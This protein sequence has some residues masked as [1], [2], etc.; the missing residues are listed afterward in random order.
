MKRLPSF[1]PL[2]VAA[3]LLAASLI[4]VHT[5]ATADLFGA[6]KDIWGS[7]SQ[8]LPAV[9]STGKQALSAAEITSGLKEALT[10]GT[11]RVVDQL[12]SADGFLKDQSIHI[13]LPESLGT[14]QNALQ[15][16]GMSGLLDDLETRLNRAAE[17]ATP[18]AKKLFLNAISEM[19][20]DDAMAIYNG[21]NDAITRYFQ[22]KTEKPLAQ[23]MKPIV[24]EKLHMSGAMISYNSVMGKYRSLPFVPD[25]Q[26]NLTDH[27]LDRG[28]SGI[29]HYLALEEA[30]IR[31]NP[32]KRTTELLQKVFGSK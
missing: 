25:V 32:V 10:V 31:T 20:I 22:T 23:A 14:V 16:I 15:K 1:C 6:A 24:D 3:I 17:Q 30:A 21:P 2:P 4:F 29:F 12:G 8:K 19:T 28:I 7:V 27:V 26:A 13:P 9:G 18:E 5:P 11:G